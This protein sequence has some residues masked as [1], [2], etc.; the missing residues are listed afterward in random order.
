MKYLI[1]ARVSERGSGFEGQTTIPMQIKI[2]EDYIRIMGGE[3]FD[4]RSDEFISGKNIEDRPAF[5]SIMEE[6]RSGTAEWDAIIVYK[7]SRISRSLRDSLNIVAELQ[8]HDKGFVSATEHFDCTTTTGQLFFNMLQS[9][10][11]FERKRTADTIRDKMM[12]IAE[13]GLWPAGRTPY[14]YKRGGRKDNNLYVDERAAEVIRDIFNQYLS[15]TPVWSIVRKYRNIM[16]RSRIF[17]TLKNPV[18]VGAIPYGGKIFPGKHQAII[19]KDVFERVQAKLPTKNGNIRP[20]AHRYPYLL[21]GIIFCRC[22]HRMTPETAKSGRYAYY[23]CV[24]AEYC[25]RRI[26]AEKVEKSVIDFFRNTMW[27]E[28]IIEKTLAQIDADAAKQAENNQPEITRLKSVITTIKAERERIFRM[29]LSSELSQSLVNMANTKIADL[30][31]E[32]SGLTERLVLLE[33]Q[34]KI[35]SE[36]HNLAKTLLLRTRNFAEALETAGS[37]SKE[38]LRQILL[39]Y[40]QKVV[41]IDDKTCDVIVKLG[42]SSTKDM[43]WY[44]QSVEPTT[45]SLSSK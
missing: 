3:V 11:E 27:S 15:D 23:R 41:S 36:A 33:N 2:C 8:E 31:E 42:K 5:R 20:K 25:K 45:R 30:D 44:T 43:E 13:A 6:L 40:I 34:K 7:F 12:S 18:Y 26:S 38:E 28:R 14:G 1:Y 37:I 39:V 16:S 4:R 22:G 10:N 32:L 9:F 29:L 21:G 19:N 24:D 17:L 35:G